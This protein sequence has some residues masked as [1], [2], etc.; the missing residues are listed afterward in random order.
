MTEDD[1]S[2]YVF[3]KDFNR[4]MYSEAKTKNQHKKYHFM[5]CL[6]SFTKEQILDQYKQNCLLINRRQAVK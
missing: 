4:L 1:K 5:H 2:S 3:I 6:Q